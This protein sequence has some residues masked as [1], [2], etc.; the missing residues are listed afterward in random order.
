MM[1]L[2]NSQENMKFNQVSIK[3]KRNKRHRYFNNNNK[4]NNNTNKIIILIQD[5]VWII[6][7]EILMVYQIEFMIL[8]YKKFLKRIIQI[9]QSLQKIRILQ[10]IQI[11]KT[12]QII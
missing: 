2:N 12:K 5:K 3:I 4:I 11:Q 6:Q 7:Q 9:N 1:D 8:K 10:E